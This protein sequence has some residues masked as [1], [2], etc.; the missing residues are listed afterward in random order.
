MSPSSKNDTLGYALNIVDSFETTWRRFPHHPREV[1]AAGSQVSWMM[2]HTKNNTMKLVLMDEIAALVP[3]LITGHQGQAAQH[4][5]ESLF[6]M[7]TDPAVQLGHPVEHSNLSYKVVQSGN[8]ALANLYEISNAIKKDD[9]DQTI[10]IRE[11]I[12][13]CLLPV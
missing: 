11:R 13:N 12:R 7:V 6:D 3:A 9:I 8:I 5:I 10:A 1:M 2:K 4:F